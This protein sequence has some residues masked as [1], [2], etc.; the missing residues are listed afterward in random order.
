[1]GYAAASLGIAIGA[2]YRSGTMALAYYRGNL[3]ARSFH[4]TEWEAVYEDCRKNAWNHVWQ[5]LIWPVTVVRSIMPSIIIKLN[6]PTPK[7]DAQ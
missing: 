1:M 4:K 5:G 7:P 6:P 3:T 2:S